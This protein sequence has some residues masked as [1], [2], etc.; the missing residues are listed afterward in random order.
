[1]FLKSLSRQSAF[2]Q[3]CSIGAIRVVEAVPAACRHTT[4]INRN[5]STY[6]GKI[7]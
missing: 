3:L 2:A 5:L 6:P 7:V 1:M 4:A